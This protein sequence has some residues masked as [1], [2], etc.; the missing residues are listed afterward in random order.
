MALTT[1]P[2][3]S[4]E[5]SIFSVS[6]L[7]RRAK[8]LL[9]THMPLLWVSGEISNLSQPSSGHWYFSLKD[10]RAQVRCAM[11]KNANQRLRWQ[12]Q[13][14][15]QVLVRAR[16]SIYEGRGDYQL[17]VEHMEDA[18]AGALQEAYEKLKLK[19]DQEGLFDSTKKRPLPLFPKHIGIITSPTGAAIHDIL[20]VLERRYPIAPV[21]IIPSPVQGEGAA[22][23]LTTS[24]KKAINFNHFDLLIITRGGGSIEDLWAFNDEELAR[25]IAACPIPIISAVGHEIDFTICDFVADLRAPT[26]SVS[27]ELATPDIEEYQLAVDSFHQQLLKIYAAQLTVK[28]K[29]LE[30]LTKRLR[31]PGERIKHQKSNIENAENALIKAMRNR[32][33]RHKEKIETLNKRRTRSHPAKL[34]DTHKTTL[35]QLNARHGKAIKQRVEHYQNEL[36]LKAQILNAVNPLDILSR[37]YSVASDTEGKILRDTENLN[38]GDTIN[39][40]L[41]DGRIVSQISEIKK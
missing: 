20:A 26:P 29:Q 7:N 35:K 28:Q 14:G 18:G 22:K 24:L 15:K 17:I 40:Q 23:E 16:V 11:F 37:G 5:K 21:S 8:Q 34:I 6:Q 39:T 2:L 31:H 30:F 41:A 4:P 10:D 3:K 12:P 25:A 38:L 13:S 9:E 1:H 32:L 36:R 27:A 33:E 19:L